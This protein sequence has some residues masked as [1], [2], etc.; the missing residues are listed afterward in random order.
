MEDWD[1]HSPQIIVV[2]ALPMALGSMAL[3]LMLLS[4]ISIRVRGS[5]IDRAAQER[6]PQNAQDYPLDQRSI[7]PGGSLSIHAL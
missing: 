5:C 3:G 4:P 2:V 1:L 7:P 6:C